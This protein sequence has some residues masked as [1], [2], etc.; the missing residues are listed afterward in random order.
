MVLDVKYNEHIS[1]F[2]DKWERRVKT[3]YVASQPTA[4]T[5]EPVN[6]PVD[7]CKLSH[8]L[9]NLREWVGQHWHPH[10]L[11]NFKKWAG[12]LTLAYSV[13]DLRDWVSTGPSTDNTQCAHCVHVGWLDGRLTWC[14]YL[15]L[16]FSCPSPTWV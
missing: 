9:L 15:H 8:S 12:R 3:E 11:S 13:L 7:Q 5:W 4:R 6:R 1:I 14:L 10:S 16:V 2:I